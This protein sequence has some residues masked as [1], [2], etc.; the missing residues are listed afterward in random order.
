MELAIFPWYRS[1]C[2][3]KEGSA[4][5]E[6]ERNARLGSCGI[7]HLTDSADVMQGIWEMPTAI[8]SRDTST[9]GQRNNFTNLI[10]PVGILMST[11]AARITF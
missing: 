8:Q 10:E 5:L 9:R 6:G 1:W 2:P 4:A 11:T 3:G 7:E